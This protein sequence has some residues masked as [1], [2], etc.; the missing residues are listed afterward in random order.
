[1]GDR[2]GVLMTLFT[3]SRMYHVDIYFRWCEDPSV[4][5]AQADGLQP[6]PRQT[7]FNYSQ[8][9]FERRFVPPQLTHMKIVSSEFVAQ[10]SGFLQNMSRVK[11][12]TSE[13]GLDQ[14]YTTASKYIK[15]YDFQDHSNFIQNYR[16]VARLVHVYALKNNFKIMV[17]DPPFYLVI[18]MHAG[19]IDDDGHPSAYCTSTV[20]REVI[21]T[22][23]P[24]G[25]LKKFFVIS[26]NQTRARSILRRYTHA[27]DFLEAH[28]SGNLDY[29]DFALLLGASG[30]IQHANYG[31]S[32]YSNTPA[33][34]ASVPLI[35]TYNWPTRFDTI[36]QH[37]ALPLEFYE[38]GTLD[39]FVKRLRQKYA[40]YDE[41][42][43][44]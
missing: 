24:F 41:D 44:D 10:N 28:V 21:Q 2:V 25:S 16:V 29:N 8:E 35:A 18:H 43:L 26:N 9:E 22:F 17:R 11:Y 40:M 15:V 36:R 3:L 23:W 38:C 12:E 1:M 33:M 39:A 27:L 32:S 6:R 34:I 14:V 7:G 19:D 31:W 20:V 37:G 13:A 5:N 30:I 4:M 42:D